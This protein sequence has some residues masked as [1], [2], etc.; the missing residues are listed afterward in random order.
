MKWCVC[1][2]VCVSQKD[3]KQSGKWT[4]AQIMFVLYIINNLGQLW[5]ML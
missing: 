5:R 3:G 4:I 2:C 1:V